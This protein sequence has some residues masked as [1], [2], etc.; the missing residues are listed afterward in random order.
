LLGLLAALG[1]GIVLARSESGLSLR[2]AMRRSSPWLGVIVVLL[3]AGWCV[4][5]TRS[6][7]MR[8]LGVIV[9][10]LA[11]GGAYYLWRLQR[12]ADQ[13]LDRLS[14]LTSLKAKQD[15]WKERWQIKYGEYRKLKD[16]GDTPPAELLTELTRLRLEWIGLA[17]RKVA[18]TETPPQGE[19]DLSKYVP[20]WRELGKEKPL[21]IVWGVDRAHLTEGGS[22]ALLAWEAKADQTGHRCA[23]MADGTTRLVDEETFGGLPK[24]I[25]R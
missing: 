6:R 17:Y 7:A 1:V 16:R 22:K 25:G 20:D 2:E 4:L 14:V 9:L 3:G 5:T 21:V 18:L 12:D 11:A 10:L 19:G 8:G 23:L 13:A 15:D 24:A